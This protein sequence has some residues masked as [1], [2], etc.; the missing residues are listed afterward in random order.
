MIIHNFH[1][2]RVAIRPVETD[3]PLIID[4]DAPLPQPITRQPLQ[5][6]AWRDSEILN[7][8]G[9]IQYE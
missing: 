9:G 5:T 1:V 3:T 7:P 6:I 2:T 8:L 4:A